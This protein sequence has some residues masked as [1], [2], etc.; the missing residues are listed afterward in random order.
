M[1][2]IRNTQSI[3]AAKDNAKKKT[4]RY[5]EQDPEKVKAYL[6]AITD[7]PP[8]T[9]AY[10]DETGIDTHIH[11]PYCRA[12][13]GKKVTGQVSGKKYRRT[14]IVAAKMQNRIIEPLQYDG[15][16]DSVLFEAWFETRLLPSL[17]Q[18]TTL[19][20]DNATFHRKSKL[21]PIAEAAGH[22]II[23][24]PPYSP[25]LNFIEFF[26][27]WLK[28]R[29]QKILSNFGSFDCALSNCFHVR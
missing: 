2:G 12:K 9:I 27:S 23:F 26:W 7:I 10:I 5:R 3:E 20:M 15:T 28:R 4:K 29:L 13:R 22:R 8:E 25:E 17:P 19:I 11:R 16:M 6:E 1:R 21:N 18:R 24:L 14:G